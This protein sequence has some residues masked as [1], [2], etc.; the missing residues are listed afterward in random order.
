MRGA[1]S[2]LLFTVTLRCALSAPRRATARLRA[3]SFEARHGSR[4]LP[5][6]AVTRLSPASPRSVRG[7]LR[8]TSLRVGR[9]R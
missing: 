8:M 2:A 1:T 5:S 9:I 6:S 3:A 4:L 7:H